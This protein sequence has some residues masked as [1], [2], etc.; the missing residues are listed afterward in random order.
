M[1]AQQIREILETNGIT[2]IVI[3]KW[4]WDIFVGKGFD[5]LF[6]ILQGE[7]PKY[8]NNQLIQYQFGPWFISPM[9]E[10]TK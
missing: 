10:Y 7:N 9:S 3:I 1:N 5:D 2:D 8:R 6:E 4:E